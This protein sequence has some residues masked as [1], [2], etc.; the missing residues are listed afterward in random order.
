MSSTT[1]GV[2]FEVMDLSASYAVVGTSDNYSFTHNL[3]I[4]SKLF[5]EVV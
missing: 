1:I 3:G 2:Q 4:G 5:D